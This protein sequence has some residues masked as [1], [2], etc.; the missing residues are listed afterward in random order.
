MSSDVRAEKRALRAPDVAK[1]K[2]HGLTSTQVVAY[3]SENSAARVQSSIIP[4][5]DYT[6]T[7]LVVD[8]FV[9]TQTDHQGI[10]GTFTRAYTATG[11]TQT[12]TDGRGNTR[13]PA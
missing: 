12:A 5:S 9:T 1:T 11:I 13:I 6:A 3:L 4:T 7:T 8:G 2:D 10:T